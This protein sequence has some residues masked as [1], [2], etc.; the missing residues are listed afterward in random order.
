MSEE[1]RNRESLVD[2]E[3]S[4]G[5]AGESALSSD[6]V[7]AEDEVAV[8][9]LATQVEELAVARD[10]LVAENAELREHLLRRQADFE[11]LRR[12]VENERADFTRYA[13]METMG[14]LLP[15]I[16]DFERALEAAPSAEDEF[17]KGIEIIYRRFLSTLEKAGLEP[18]ESVGRPFDPNF[19]HAVETVP[20]DEFDDHT[21]IEE[22]RKG[23]NFKGKLLREAMV[24]VSVRASDSAGATDSE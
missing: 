5:R 16:D 9:D 10:N 14:E 17:V 12:R 8:D 2:S 1:E 4:D 22:Y 23:Y 7:P 13:A 19:H 3:S 15:L 18:I 20:T 21:V 24:R 6:S 11:N